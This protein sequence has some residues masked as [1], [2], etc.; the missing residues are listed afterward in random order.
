MLEVTEYT[1]VYGDGQ[2]DLIS[3]VKILLTQGWQPFSG[4]T[5]KPYSNNKSDFYQAMVKYAPPKPN[6][7]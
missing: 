1:L 3:K 5:L 7:I 2:D 4:L 6:Q